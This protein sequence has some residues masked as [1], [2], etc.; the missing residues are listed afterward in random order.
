MPSF[1]DE[2]QTFIMR[3]AWTG[4]LE[5]A[6]GEPEFIVAYERETGKIAGHISTTTTGRVT[7][8]PLDS[9]G[10]FILDFAAWFNVNVW[11][12]ME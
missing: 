2:I 6:L 11:G 9:I 4:A 8:Q 1:D 5:W 12:D 10:L 3:T 7:D